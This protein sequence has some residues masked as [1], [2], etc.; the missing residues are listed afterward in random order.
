MWQLELEVP[1]IRAMPCN[2]YFE[3]PCNMREKGIFS[4]FKMS[5]NTG[6]PQLFHKTSNS[7]QNLQYIYIYIYR[8]VKLGVA[9][10]ILCKQPR[11]SLQVFC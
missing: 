2:I 9:T 4:V 7:L 11:Q 1:M 10:F 6:L 5:Q 3:M 8:T